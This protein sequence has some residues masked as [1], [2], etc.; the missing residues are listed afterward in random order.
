M[1]TKN[2]IRINIQRWVPYEKNQNKTVQPGK[3]KN[4]DET[5]EMKE[6]K[7]K[8]CEIA[9]ESRDFL[10][11]HQCKIMLEDEKIHCSSADT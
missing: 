2:S 8:N 5:E 7:C 6:V 9:E 11:I 3:G 10:S 4:Q 1:D